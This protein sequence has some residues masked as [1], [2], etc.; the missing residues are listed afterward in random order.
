[1]L[2][3]SYTSREYQSEEQENRRRGIERV[4]RSVRL[5]DFSDEQENYKGRGRGPA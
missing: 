3:E 2:R 4:R 1:M 5:N